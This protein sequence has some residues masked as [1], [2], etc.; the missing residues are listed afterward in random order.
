MYR[1]LNFFLLAGLALPLAAQEFPSR[2]LRVIC[3]FPPGGPVDVTARAI[4]RELSK[5]LNQPVVV[6][7]RPGAGGNIGAEA[8][9]RAAPDGYTLFVTWNALHAINPLL[10]SKMTYDPN[11]DLAPVAQLVSLRQVLVVHPGVAANSVKEVIALAKGQPGKLTYGT[12]GNGTV[13]HMAGTM[14]AQI[15]G[16]DIVHVPYKGSAPAVT[17]LLAG[18]ITMMFDHI[19][20]V[21]PQI[22]AGKLRAIATSGTSRNAMLPHLPTIAESGVPG[23]DTSV[24][25]GVAVAAGT[26]KDIVGRLNAESVKGA[27]SP[28]FVKVMTD[29]GY[30]VIPSTPEQMA[31]EIRTEIARW[32]PI[33]KASSAKID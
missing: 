33:V 7:N 10:Q 20:S 16:V 6:E 17:D 12:P 5:Q 2:P 11:K 8:A 22:K 30:E 29:L 14:F 32:T 25:F 9:A 3:A 31:N 1:L 26:P 4:A 18:Q 15:A 28:D 13:S 24:W 21:L 19:P 23:F 27:K